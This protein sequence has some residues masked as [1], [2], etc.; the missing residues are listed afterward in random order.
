M[1]EVLAKELPGLFVVEENG[2]EKEAKVTRAR[3][4]EKLL[5]KVLKL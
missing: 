4:N 3:G 1:A 5:E 2:K